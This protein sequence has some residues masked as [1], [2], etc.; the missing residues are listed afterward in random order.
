MAADIDGANARWVTQTTLAADPFRAG[1]QLAAALGLV[2]GV[3][4]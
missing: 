4:A 1:W 3:H 2:S